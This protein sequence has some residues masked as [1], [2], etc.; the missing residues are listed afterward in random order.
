MEEVLLAIEEKYGIECSSKK[1]SIH[2]E[3]KSTG[4]HDEGNFRQW[5]ESITIKD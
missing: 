2:Y 4:D 1:K 3:I 5:V